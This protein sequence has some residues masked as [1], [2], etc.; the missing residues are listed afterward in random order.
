MTET[1][2]QTYEMNDD[3]QEMDDHEELDDQDHLTDL[4]DGSGCTEIWEHL[5]EKRDGGGEN[6]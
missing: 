3:Q 6:S 5:A 4:P 1:T 2:D